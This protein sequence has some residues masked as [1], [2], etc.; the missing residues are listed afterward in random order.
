LQAAAFERRTLSQLLTKH[1]AVYEGC[2]LAWGW[3]GPGHV[4]KQSQ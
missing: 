1:P 4:H 3:L 2:V